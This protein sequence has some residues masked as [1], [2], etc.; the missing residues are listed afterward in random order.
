[1]GLKIRLICRPVA[2]AAGWLLLALLVAGRLR[3]GDITPE[4]QARL[5]MAA[6]GEEVPV[7]VSFSARVDL[8][9]FGNLLSE[10]RGRSREKLVRALRGL[11]E[12]SQHGVVAYLKQ[13]GSSRQTVLWLSNRLAVLARPA[14]VIEVAKMPGV[15]CIGLDAAVPLGETTSGAISADG[16]NLATLHVPEMWT[17]G[18][19]GTG[20]TVA[21]LDTG[22][23][24]LHPDL[25]DR[26]R[27]GTNSWF[28]PNGQHA[29][30]YDANGHGTQVMGLL[31]GGS[32]GGSPIGVA[33]GAR[34]IAAKIF[35]DAGVASFS[36]IH[37][38]YQWLLDPDGNPATDDAP[39]IV[40]N[41]WGLQGSVN[42][43]VQ[44]FHDD[45]AALRAA[46]VAV[47]FAAG[48]EGPGPASSLSPANDPGSFAVG[49]LSESLT[50][51]LFSSRGPGAC[52]G[53]IYPEVTAPGVNLRTA[54]TTLG[55]VFPN[56]YTY[57]LGTSFA[58]PQVAG[59]LALLRQAFPEL[60]P[61]DL[62]AGLLA[63]AEDLGTAG[64]DNDYGHGL[65]D[66]VAAYALLLN[67]TMGADKDGDGYY[68]GPAGGDHPD[69]NDGDPTIHPGAPEIKHDGIDQ[70]CNGYDLTIDILE[71]SYYPATDTL[72]V[73]ATSELLVSGVIR[74]SGLNLE[75][76]GPMERKGTRRWM[77]WEKTVKYAH[78]KPESVVVSGVE[79]ATS[80][81][82]TPQ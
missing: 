79:G 4:L 19:D 78:G 53:R 2:A 56:A 54:N 43:C 16:W 82:V 27:G 44:E 31:V 11:A 3:A 15:A 18:Y 49:A 12:T 58:A 24:V 10:G 46:G 77:W 68:T 9:R 7:I 26:W 45:L 64:P 5:R 61:A 57:V 25:Q 17:L 76:F 52:D 20:V 70:D 36:G 51:A 67:Q 42:Q 28:D 74:H 34:W 35:N 41:S 22:V 30:P 63:A 8:S 71:A 40:N 32:A 1:M 66:F 6:P 13:R 59:G 55:G 50:V 37:L 47:V 21:S 33:P 72:K 38:A 39:D 62:E 23:D 75:G 69:C 60:P 73:R 48:N 80:A 65:P 81:P 14:V 29:T